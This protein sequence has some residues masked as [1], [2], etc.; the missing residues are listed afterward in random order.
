MILILTSGSIINLSLFLKGSRIIPQ[1]IIAP[2]LLSYLNDL[3]DKLDLIF[4]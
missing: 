3:A 2:M 1:L 4:K